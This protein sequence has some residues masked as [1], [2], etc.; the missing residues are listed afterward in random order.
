MEN[1]AS[2]ILC[3]ITSLPSPFGIGDF[4]PA[5]YAFADFLY[6]TRQS[7]WQVLPINPTDPGT[8]YSPYNSLSAFAG[9]I[10][11]ISPEQLCRAGLL[12]PS[13][14]KPPI[15]GAGIDYAE[16]DQAKR[17]L[18]QVARGEF[19]KR[20]E[21]VEPYR[22]FCDRN[23]WWLEEYATFAA[24]RD[25][26]AGNALPEW[27]QPVRTRSGVEYGQLLEE[28]SEEVEQGKFEQYI[29]FE[30]WFSLKRYCNEKGIQIIGD[31]PFF[32]DTNAAEIWAHPN[33]FQVDA[34]TL[35][36]RKVAGAPPDSFAENGQL[37]GCTA[38]NW[39]QH[40][41]DGFSWWIRRMKCML[42]L[43]DV[44]RV[45][46]F[47][48]WV[49]C[50]EVPAE[51]QNALKGAW[52]DVPFYD[53]MNRLLKHLPSLPIFAEDLGLITPDVR[54]AMGKYHIPGIKMLL[55]GFAKEM[56]DDEFLL[57]NHVENSVVYTGTHDTNT[58][59]GWF[60]KED[61]QDDKG[62]AL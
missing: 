11:L 5:A 25:R 40:K 13:Q 8:S 41:N 10:H 39:N 37:F 20:P 14:L 2:G 46:H 47:R 44:V 61:N 38:Y 12:S 54:E 19:E 4:G 23:A 62:V 31:F 27:P 45:D 22:L 1:R 60:Q 52:R 35:A 21:L 7:Y 56:R 24:L 6:E 57:H 3:H 36:A 48:G 18:L 17:A 30:Q 15:P 42:E 32:M 59:V 33:L 58:I 49:A 53:F 34:N 43:Y 26:F 51:D 29:F 28:M 9:N 55:F 16:V 50:W